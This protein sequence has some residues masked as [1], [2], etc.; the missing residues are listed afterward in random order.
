MTGLAQDSRVGA[1]LIMT[2]EAARQGQALIADVLWHHG[3]GEAECAGC[4]RLPQHIANLC[5]FRLGGGTPHRFFT[6][7]PMT[8]G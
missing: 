7:R 1:Q 8:K 4:H 6:H 3:E 5:R 2:G